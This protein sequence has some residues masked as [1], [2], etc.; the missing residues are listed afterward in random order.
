MLVERVA[1]VILNYLNYGDTIEC[2]ESIERMDYSLCGIV[3]VDNGSDN[4]S[5]ERISRVCKGKNQIHILQTHKNLGYAK[6]NNVGI[7]YARKRLKANYVLVVNNDTLF[8]QKDYINKLVDSH[9]K[10]VAV[11][12]S[13]VL[14]KGGIQYQY[15]ENFSL[16]DNLSTYMNHFTKLRGCCFDFP[17]VSNEYKYIL[18]GCALMF[19]PDFFKYYKGFYS[20]TFL[21][22]EEQILYLMCRMKGLK[23]A[24]VDDAEIFHKE[25]QSS[26]L[27]FGNNNFTK[28][29]YILQSEKYVLWWLLK[30]RFY[31]VSKGIRIIPK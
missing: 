11:V 18:H 2:I 7:H 10:G 19:T 16:R 24:Y 23:Q 3:V 28:L 17:L 21:Y 26:E 8:I 15:K 4:D 22:Y 31:N 20:R 30:E 25:D 14:L 29:R 1:I 27:S 6:G 9:Q 12:G 5:I 13:K